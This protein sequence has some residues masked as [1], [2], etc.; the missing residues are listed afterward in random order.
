MSL[1]MPQEA[2]TLLTEAMFK[3]L[4]ALFTSALLARF[5]CY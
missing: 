4:F 2:V 3:L 5:A 1:N